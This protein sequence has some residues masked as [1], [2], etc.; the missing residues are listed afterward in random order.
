[1]FL[2]HVKRLTKL[3]VPNCRKCLFP[4]T[5]I[6]YVTSIPLVILNIKVQHSS[7]YLTSPLPFSISDTTGFVSVRLLN[8]RLQIWNPLFNYLLWY[9]FPLIDPILRKVFSTVYFKPDYL[10][11]TNQTFFHTGFLY[12]VE[13]KIVFLFWV[14]VWKYYYFRR[15]FSGQELYHSRNSDVTNRFIYFC[16]HRKVSRN[17]QLQIT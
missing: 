15:S 11:P 10:T 2:L 5:S 4:T 13:K 16:I 9:R 12:V 14:R 6:Y 1:M 3:L 17:K 7:L 8:T